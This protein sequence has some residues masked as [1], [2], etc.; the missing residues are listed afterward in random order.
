RH[1]KGP[2]RALSCV[3]P[4]TPVACFYSAPLARFCS[5]V[6]TEYLQDVVHRKSD[7]YRTF[8]LAKRG[9]A[10]V[11]PRPSRKHRWICVPEPM[12]M[13]A[14]RWIAQ[15]I[16]NAVTPHEAC[17]AFT[18]KRDLVGAAKKH[19]QARWLVKL[20]I[21][22]F[23]ESI[24]EKSVY[25][26]FR[27]LGY[28][29]LLSF[30]FARLC[31][32]V[33]R[34]D[35]IG[36]ISRERVRSLPIRPRVPGHLPQGAPTSPML[37]NLAVAILDDHLSAIGRG[38]GWTYTRYA[39]DL[40]FSRIEDTNRGSAVTLVKLVEFALFDFGFVPHSAKTSIASPGARKVLLGTLVDRERPRLTRSFRNNL[41]THLYA[42][43]N[44]GIGP[45]AHVRRRGFTSM[46]GLR[47]HVAGLL[48]FA[49]QVDPIYAAKQYAKF[50]L[51]DWSK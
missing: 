29:A 22:R 13:Q 4:L 19:L 46:I 7:P 33:R 17:H 48:A 5:D 27:R 21:R 20:D 37:A 32:R 6:D 1:R 12:L 40:A 15:N 8:K 49:H 47:R 36:K 44:D 28:P 18:L 25:F 34:G 23:F 45:A 31:T 14:Q 39:D 11:R 16:L 35:L 9:K 30:Q 38:H 42:M 51:I 43:T 2:D 10:N 50:N 3:V 24:P 26:V 41:E